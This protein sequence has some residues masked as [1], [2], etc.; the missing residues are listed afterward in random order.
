MPDSQPLAQRV[1]NALSRRRGIE[2]RRMFGCVGFLLKGNMLVGIWKDSL[3]VRLGRDQAKEALRE[4]DV[5]P[6]DITG[7]PMGGWA[8]VSRTGLEGDDQIRSWI[9]RARRFVKT[10]PP[11]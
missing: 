4:P 5:G 8:L 2:E 11:K 3:V 9:E 7:R 1:R 10:L 6:F